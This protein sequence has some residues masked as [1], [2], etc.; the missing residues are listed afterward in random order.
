MSNNNDI[1]ISSELLNDLKNYSKEFCVGLATY[2]RDELFCAAQT[3]V[4]QFYIDYT[5][6]EY[7]R[8]Y[9]NFNKSY[10][11]Y[12]SN[13][14][15]TII[16]GGVELSFNSMD[17]LYSASVDAVFDSFYSGFHGAVAIKTGKPP[18]MNPTPLETI[19]AWR[20]NLID[21]ISGAYYIAKRRADSGRYST[22]K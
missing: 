20:D 15:G 17:D 10:S 14:H 5:P 12:Y 1:R 19:E 18:Q 9:T 8:H 16:R 7:K 22:I 6:E 3:A 11:K 21:Y 13:A 4:A 2:V